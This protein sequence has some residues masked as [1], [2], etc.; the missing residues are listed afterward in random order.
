MEMQPLANPAMIGR[1]FGG[2]A[3]ALAGAPL[4]R[5]N[6]Y[7]RTMLALQS[8]LNQ[9][10]HAG[11]ADQQTQD[12]NAA[13][14]GIQQL[15][16]PA[17]QA[18]L[19]SYTGQKGA[20]AVLYNLVRAGKLGDPD[21]LAKA[22]RVI[23]IMHMSATGQQQG[24][25]GNLPGMNV[26]LASAGLKPANLGAVEGNTGVSPF[27]GQISAPT[28]VGGSIIN[29]NQAAA[30]HSNA[31]AALDVA[32]SLTQHMEQGGTMPARPRA[33]PAAGGLSEPVLR[34]L[35]LG[36]TTPA[37][38]VTPA[39][40]DPAKYVREYSAYNQAL[41]AHPGISQAQA[42]QIGLAAGA[43]PAPAAATPA[44]APTPALAPG[45]STSI[46]PHILHQLFGGGTAPPAAP[47]TK[48]VNW[49]DLVKQKGK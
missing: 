45:D 46:I 35:Q 37:S 3:A 40:V 48:T 9:R 22:A 47:A 17:V 19:D 36:A 8:G 34:A 29:R 10:A 12:L 4:A 27:T 15:G 31:G 2:G 25:A 5:Q 44:A 16:D 11:L 49:S 18:Q 43:A 6:A 13:E 14:Q 23:Q 32:R 30:G 39:S 7:T 41:A 21:S 42:V 38:G 28:A 1:T 24:N 26:D 20:G 33:A